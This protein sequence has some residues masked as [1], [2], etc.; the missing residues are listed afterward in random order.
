[1]P[2]PVRL[3]E[4]TA[5]S[6]VGTKAILRTIRDTL[7]IYTRHHGN[8]SYNARVQGLLGGRIRHGAVTVRTF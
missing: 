2:A 8:R 4:R 3:E 7:G 1:V 6:T 5:G